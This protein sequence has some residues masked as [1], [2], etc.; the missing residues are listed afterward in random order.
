MSAEVE[1]HENQEPALLSRIQSYGVV[2]AAADYYQQIKNYSP[3]AT[4]R[5]L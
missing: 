4:V 5:T 2:S 3:L 1:S